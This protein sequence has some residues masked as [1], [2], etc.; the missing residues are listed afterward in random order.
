MSKLVETPESKQRLANQGYTVELTQKQV[1]GLQLSIFDCG[2]SS[3][4]CNSLRVINENGET[5]TLADV[6]QYSSS[7]L[8]KFRNFGKNSLAEIQEKLAQYNLKFNM[9]V[10]EIEGKYF[11]HQYSSLH[12]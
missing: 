10:I 7:D 11:T 5:V 3:R 2:F 12:R 9:D 8:L 1:A 4:V 6:V